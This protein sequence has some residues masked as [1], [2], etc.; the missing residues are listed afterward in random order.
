MSF[1]SYL[2]TKSKF[3]APSY[4]Q[5]I[6]SK[7]GSFTAKQLGFR[8]QRLVEPSS[9]QILLEDQWDAGSRG[10][11]RQARRGTSQHEAAEATHEINL[12]SKFENGL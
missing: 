8:N 4:M 1:Q 9:A 10:S 2:S 7:D 11:F 6:K 3:A 12:V 5:S